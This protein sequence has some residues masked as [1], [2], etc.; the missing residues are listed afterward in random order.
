MT[1]ALLPIMVVC[2]KIIR[3][4]M[5][6]ILITL[7]HPRVC[8]AVRLGSIV[9][10]KKLWPVSGIYQLNSD[11]HGNIIVHTNMAHGRNVSEN[12][13]AKRVARTYL[14]AF[15]AGI[16]K[17]FWYNL[18][19]YENDDKDMESHFG[20]LHKDLS[21]KPAYNAFKTLIDNLPNGSTRPVVTYD[22]TNDL[23]T[24]TW[25]RPD[26]K[27]V[28]AYWTSMRLTT[29]RLPRNLANAKAVDFL[30]N[31]VKTNGRELNVA[32]SVVFITEK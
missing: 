10:Q 14:V 31:T 13:Q 21:P 27:A 19:S 9:T 22:K 24:A 32:N 3:Q 7:A 18:R 25:K 30:G 26:G 29:V 23:Y 20:L 11:L 4:L 8:G 16:S 15:A 2:A 28:T 1:L 6:L 5:R 17:V 12:L